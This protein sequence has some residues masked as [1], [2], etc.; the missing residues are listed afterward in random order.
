[1]GLTR[2]THFVN[3]TSNAAKVAAL[4]GVYSSVDEVDAWVGALAEDHVTGASV[5]ELIGTI[6]K[7]QFER[8]MFGD[9]YFYL[10]VKDLWDEDLMLNVL[11]LRVVTLQDI[12]KR[13]TVIDHDSTVSAFI[14]QSVTEKPV[15]PLTTSRSYDGTDRSD[16]KGAALSPLRRLSTTS[17]TYTDETETMMT[18]GNPRH[19]SNTVFD[20]TNGN[21]Q[22]V[23]KFNP[24]SLLDMVSF[25]LHSHFGHC[26]GV[27][28]GL[29]PCCFC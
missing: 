28:G 13:N 14:K 27:G 29:S 17:M 12:I 3:I 2:Y 22:H 21:G 1:M 16:E 5:G 15:I 11:D 6:M 4:E 9:P 26:W 23:D 10:S 8:L 24:N 20:Q 19:I 25:Y 7:D 18:G